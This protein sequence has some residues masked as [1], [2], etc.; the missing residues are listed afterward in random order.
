[1]FF[2]SRRDTVRPLPEKKKKHTLRTAAIVLL[3]I[4]LLTGA[5][6]AAALHQILREVP[7][8]SEIDIT[9]SGNATIVYD[10]AGDPIRQL[11][12]AEGNRISVSIEEIPAD[13]QHAIVAIE[14]SRFYQHHGVD[15]KGMLRAAVNAVRSGFQR[16]E[17]AST[18]TQQLLKNN[19]FTGWMEEDGIWDS[20]KRKLQE[21]YLALELEKYLAAQGEDAKSVILENYLNTVNFGS[22]AYGIQKAAQIYFGKD[23]KDLTLSECAVLAAIPQNPTRWDPRKDPEENAKRRETVLRYMFEQGWIT[24][25]EMQEALADDVYARI[26]QNGG[27]AE[28]EPYSYFIDELIREVTADLIR[29]KGYTE[30]EAER[31]LYSGGL[32]IYSTQSTEIQEIMEE[33]FQKE[34]NA[35]AVTLSG[36]NGEAMPQAAMTVIEQSSGQVKGIIGGRGEK[37][38]SLTLNRA[39]DLPRQPGSAFKILSAYGPA[40]EEGDITLATRIEDEPYEYADGTSL[41]NADGLYHGTVSVRTAI[42][43]SYNI[44]AVKVLSEITPRTGFAYLTRLGFT[45]LHEDADLYEPLALGGISE[46]VTNLEL[47]AAYAAVAD[48]GIY[49]APVFYTRVT[50][51]EGTVL[52]ENRDAGT[53]VFAESTAYLLT[54]AMESAVEEGTGTGYQLE[55]MTAAGKTG[56]TNSYKDLVF[57]GYT[58]YYTAAVWAGYDDGREV[59]EDGRTFPQKLWTGVMNRIHENLPDTGFDPPADVEQAAVCAESGLRPGFGCPRTEEYFAEGTAPTEKCR[60]HGWFARPTEEPEKPAETPEPEAPE[61]DLSWWDRL[62]NWLR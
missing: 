13:M 21:Q 17:C 1:M 57:A 27:Q 30:E 46:G 47:T 16:L 37:E 36:E 29:E 31:M 45:T 23:C 33:E 20:I 14:D 34:E 32:R 22:G 58:P 5:L 53:R 8:I 50:D 35:P 48:G 38:A 12:L 40:L 52:L 39:A 62:W 11:N 44:P 19:V 56:T 42:E 51:R 18:I 43:E 49:H 54:S 2:R 26:R 15:Y 28:E 25:G 9:P 61:E 60:E 7:D 55:D 10:D 6:G 59:P 3:C 24:D 4:L 41:K